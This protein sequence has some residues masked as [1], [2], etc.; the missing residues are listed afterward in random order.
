L[1][2]VRPGNLSRDGEGGVKSAGFDIIDAQIHQPSPPVPLDESVPD[3]LK[4]LL[5]VELAREAMDSVGVDGALLVAPLPY[6]D[7]CIARYPGRFIGVETFMAT[8]D[9]L[10]LAV[11]RAASDARLIAGRLLVTDFRT[12]ELSANF[13]SGGM[14]AG[15]AAAEAAGL[16]LFLSTHGQSAA[17][18]PLIERHPRLTVIIDHIGVS[19][20]P[21]SPARDHPWDRFEDLLP[22]AEFANVHVKLCGAPLLSD[23]AYPFADVWPNLHRLIAAFGAGRL[24]WASDYTRLR[25]AEAGGPSRNRGCLYSETRDM[26]LHSAEIDD[27]AKAAILGGTVKRVLGWGPSAA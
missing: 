13:A 3:D 15:F 12:T 9:D 27:A 23:Q 20:H 2:G 16:P 7:A 17:M 21:V 22:L 26:L 18:R 19:Q 10:A 8:D 4:R 1:R 5:N 11:T 14:D 25:M 24:M 6:I